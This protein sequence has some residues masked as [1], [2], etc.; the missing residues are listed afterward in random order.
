[1][2]VLGID[3]AWTENQP[4]GISLLSSKDGEHC[5][6]LQLGDSY[7]NFLKNRKYLTE[8]PKGSIN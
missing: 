5:R 2:L 4:S 6:V 7:V 1:M 3:A 8:K